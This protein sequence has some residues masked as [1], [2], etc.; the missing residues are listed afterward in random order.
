MNDQDEL[1]SH[2]RDPARV[3]SELSRVTRSVLALAAV[4][5]VGALAAWWHSGTA[6]QT[7]ASPGFVGVERT[8]A[9]APALAPR[10]HQVRVSTTSQRAVVTSRGHVDLDLELVNDGSFTLSLLNVRM[11]QPGVRAD[12]GPGGLISSS[13]IGQLAPDTPTLITLH[14][15]VLCPQGLSGKPADHLEL[16]LLDDRGST[17]STAIDLRPLPG[18]WDHVRHSACTSGGS[19]LVV[20]AMPTSVRW[21]DGTN[22][23]LT[24]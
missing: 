2:G 15:V 8:F 9:P 18:F 11:P 20:D 22:G 7:V 1:L 12:P 10:L 4:L 24:G 17:R 21:E 14:L 23:P 6:P 13:K 5:V 3:R 19:G 16:T